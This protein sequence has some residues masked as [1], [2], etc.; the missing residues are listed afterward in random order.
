[1]KKLTTIV[2]TAGLLLISTAAVIAD[3]TESKNP[4]YNGTIKIEGMTAESFS[5]AVEKYERSRDLTVSSKAE[6]GLLFSCFDTNANGEI[7][8]SEAPVLTAKKKKKKKGGGG[9][10]VE[11]CEFNT[12][13]CG[14]GSGGFTSDIPDEVGPNDTGIAGSDGVGVGRT[15]LDWCGGGCHC[16]CNT[17]QCA[18]NGT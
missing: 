17:F 10:Q 1:M 5:S 13:D 4:F 6:M 2:L 8:E 12:C 16:H 3:D 9:G 7:E 18:P 11:V 14:T 15:S